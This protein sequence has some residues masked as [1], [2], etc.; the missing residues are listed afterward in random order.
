[1]NPIGSFTVGSLVA[2]GGS[3]LFDF[4]GTSFN[5]ASDSIKVNGTA[6]LSG[7]T[8]AVNALTS[9]ASDYRFNQL[10]T[11]VQANSLTGTFA[12]GSTFATVASNP[13]LKWR[14]RYDLVANSVILQVQK[15]MEFND[16]VAAG[17][18][19]TLAVAN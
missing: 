6:T 4:G 10:Y 12:N 18:T 19:N 7:G 11:I 16:G 14:L 13:N 15:N 1:V 9:T 2:S 8:V 17:D 3:L 5:F